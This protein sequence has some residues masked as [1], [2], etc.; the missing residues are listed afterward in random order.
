MRSNKCLPAHVPHVPHEGS[1]F[2]ELLYNGSHDDEA[3]VGADHDVPEVEELHPLA[4]SEDPVVVSGEEDLSLVLEELRP[5]EGSEAEEEG[6]E[7]EEDDEQVEEH[8]EGGVWRGLQV[9]GLAVKPHRLHVQLERE[10]AVM[11]CVV[12]LDVDLELEAVGL[13]HRP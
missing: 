8:D 4:D 13:L 5:Q 7:G 12:E 11:V 10:L 3:V 9:L 1:A 6:G 2:N